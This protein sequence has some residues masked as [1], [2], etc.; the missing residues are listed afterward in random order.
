MDSEQDNYFHLNLLNMHSILKYFYC[1]EKLHL[2]YV[3]AVT[4]GIQ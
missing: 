4:D 2:L 3:N 1:F